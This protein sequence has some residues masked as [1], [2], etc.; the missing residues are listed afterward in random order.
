MCNIILSSGTLQV[1]NVELSEVLADMNTST[2][3]AYTTADGTTIY[4]RTDQ[5]IAVS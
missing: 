5:I 4:L 3:K 2:V 1:I